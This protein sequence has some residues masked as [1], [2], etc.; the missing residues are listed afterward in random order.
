MGAALGLIGPLMSIGGA[1][2]G[3]GSTASNVPQAPPV[4]QPTGQ[5]GADQG[6]QAGICAAGAPGLL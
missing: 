2:F 3:G 6:V 5:A 1:L 4:Y